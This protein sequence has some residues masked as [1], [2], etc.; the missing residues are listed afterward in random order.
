MEFFNNISTFYLI[1]FLMLFRAFLYQLPG[2]LLDAVVLVLGLGLLGQVFKL[3]ELSLYQFALF[4]VFGVVMFLISTGISSHLKLTLQAMIN[5]L[6]RL[7]RDIYWLTLL[8]LATAIYEEII[9]RG[10]FLIAMSNIAGA[11]LSVIVSS[12]FFVVWHKSQLISWRHVTEMFLFSIV[13]CVLYFI[14]ENI[15]LIITI[16]F[17]RNIFVVITNYGL[18]R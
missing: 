9:W 1:S 10:I 15:F 4:P 16:H 12:V 6:T 11:S 13:Q 3:T 2:Y 18:K 5:N 7:D 14:F 17:I 8:H